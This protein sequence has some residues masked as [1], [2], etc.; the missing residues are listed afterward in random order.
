[1]SGVLLLLLLLLPIAAQQTRI[2]FTQDQLGM[3]LLPIAALVRAVKMRAAVVAEH[4][5]SLQVHH[6]I[7]TPGAVDRTIT[8]TIIIIIIMT[9]IHS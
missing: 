3:L 2:I 4:V 5:T 9:A 7:V 6:C 8:I 1:M